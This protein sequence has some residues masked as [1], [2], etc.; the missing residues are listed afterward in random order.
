[1]KLVELEMGFYVNF[2]STKTG[3]DLTNIPNDIV[4]TLWDKSKNT[5]PTKAWY[6]IS[7]ESILVG[8]LQ[9]TKPSDVAAILSA[10]QKNLIVQF[11]KSEGGALYQPLFYI[12]LDKICSQYAKHVRD[13]TR[14]TRAACEV[15]P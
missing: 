2:T 6:P 8:S 4:W 1:M 10:P 7:K 11:A 12:S 15:D 13:L 14:P 5:I 9:L 3:A